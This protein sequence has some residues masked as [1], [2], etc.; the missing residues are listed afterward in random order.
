MALNFLKV[1]NGLTLKPNT[2]PSVPEN[3][4]V[5][6]D[7]GSNT[8]QF[9]QNGAWVSIPN[10][11]V[12]VVGAI[13]SQTPSANGLVISGVNIYAQ[14]A[15]ATVPGMVSTGTQTFAGAK[16]FSGAI[17]ASNLSGTNTGDNAVNTTYASAPVWI[18]YT[19]T[20][21]DLS[22]GATTNTVTLFSLPAKTMIHQV[23]VKHSASFTGGALS[24]YTIA[25]GDA[26]NSSRWAAAFSV[27]QAAGDTVRSITQADDLESF[28][29]ATNI[30]LTA[31]STGAN[32]SAA[33]AGSVDI[34]V[35]TS[36]LP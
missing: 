2:A 3:G 20:F 33:T 14:S 19:K 16:T 28:A 25:L 11:I 10:S 4:D 24:A 1:R 5:Y 12:S 36:L 23:V 35:L 13:D 27:F 31:T 6:Y 32:L 29:S 21:T 30:T 26:G 15:S 7:S 9:Y 8:V 18:K 34:W 17:S 22:A